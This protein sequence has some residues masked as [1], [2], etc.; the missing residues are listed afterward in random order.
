MNPPKPSSLDY[1]LFPEKN[2]SIEESIRL[3]LEAL[4][5]TRRDINDASNASVL[6][7]GIPECINKNF[8][9][10]RDQ[11]L[12]ELHKAIATFETRLSNIVITYGDEDDK[13]V[14]SVL[15]LHIHA[16]IHDQPLQITSTFNLQSGVFS[17]L[18]PN[19]E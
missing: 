16:V 14:R 12:Q 6:T 17:C 3:H 13:N 15:T 10:I 5:N 4:F 7:Y 18:E 8:Y 19:H 2:L 9:N 1:L 11:L